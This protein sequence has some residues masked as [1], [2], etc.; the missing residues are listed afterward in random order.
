MEHVI[1]MD[2]S[3]KRKRIIRLWI[4]VSLLSVTALFWL[5]LI[6]GIIAHPEGTGAV[7]LSGLVLSIIPVKA[8]I[9]CVKRAKKRY[10]RRLLYW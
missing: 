2:A 4:G 10:K 6:S 8:G 7:I 1:A 3:N 5:A 9:Y